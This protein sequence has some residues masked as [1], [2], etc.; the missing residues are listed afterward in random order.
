MRLF[1][2]SFGVTVQIDERGQVLSDGQKQFNEMVRAV[3]R[4]GPAWHGG[5]TTVFLRT[6]SSID[7]VMRQLFLISTRDP[8]DLIFCLD[9]QTEE[10]RWVGHRF[11]EDGFDEVFPQAQ[12][13]VPT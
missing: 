10:V 6:D 12:E 5:Q 2:L 8:G 1:I 4:I 3:F 13:F 9:T 7:E 11:D